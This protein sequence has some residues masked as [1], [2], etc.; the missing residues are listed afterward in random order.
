[1]TANG[2][3]WEP[4]TVSALHAFTNPGSDLRWRATFSATY[5][6]QSPYIYNITIVYGYT[7][8]PTA[9]TLT[10]PGTTIV[11]ALFWVNWTASTDPDGTVD[12]Y[13]LQMADSN[14]FTTI[15]NEWTPT[16][17]YQQVDLLPVGTYYF[18]VRAVDNDG[19]PGPWS[20][21]EDLTVQPVI[22]PPPIPGFPFEA[23]IVGAIV[24]LGLGMIYRRKRK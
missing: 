14:A 18:R 19:A 1:M 9:P 21:I 3:D 7:A 16:T 4:I 12:H 15:L 11:T 6:D 10:D 13:H 20:N 5:A 23:I 8:P 2:V 24:A 17:L 22:G